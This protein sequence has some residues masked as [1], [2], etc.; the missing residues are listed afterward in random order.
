MIKKSIHRIQLEKYKHLWLIVFDHRCII[1]GAYT[2]VLHEIIPI[3]HGVIAL[4]GK[5]RVP[6]CNSHHNWVHNVLG[7]RNS[8]ELLREKRNEYLRKKWQ[9]RCQSK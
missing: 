2:E 4:A 9:T 3:S 6:L 7:T 1:C 8:I 5:N